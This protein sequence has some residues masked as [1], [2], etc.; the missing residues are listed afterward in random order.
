MQHVGLEDICCVHC[1][2]YDKLQSRDGHVEDWGL[3]TWVARSIPPVPPLCPMLVYF[4]RGQ[5]V[6]E[7]VSL[8]FRCIYFSEQPDK[9]AEWSVIL[10]TEEVPV[11]AVNLF[12]FSPLRSR[13][14]LLK[15]G[16][17]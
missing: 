3:D 5:S 13:A 2:V 6:P 4:W 16:L 17:Y 7:K 8:L 11:S 10:R 15:W 1:I 9:E 14:R 12:L